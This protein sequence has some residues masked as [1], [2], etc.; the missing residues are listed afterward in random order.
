VQHAL[1]FDA[2]RKTSGTSATGEPIRDYP[3]I[4]KMDAE[5]KAKVDARW[6]EYGLG[7]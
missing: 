6:D 7:S 2:T 1:G 5:T 4:L 3:P